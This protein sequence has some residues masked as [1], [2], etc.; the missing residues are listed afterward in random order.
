MVATASSIYA[1]IG[2][3]YVTGTALNAPYGT[4]L[5]VT[6]QAFFEATL[7]VGFI[8]CGF[9]GEKG[10][11][12]S[13]PRKFF[14][15]KDMSGSLIDS[16]Q[17][18]FSGVIK[19]TFLELN[20]ETLGNLHGD[21]N[22]ASTAATAGTGGRIAFPITGAP[23]D[24]SSWVFR[25]KAGKK[26]VGVVVPRA[27]VTTQSDLTFSA[28]GTASVDVEISTIPTY[29]GVLLANVSCYVITDDG[30][31]TVSTV[32]TIASVTPTG[33]GATML[34]TIIGTRFTGTVATTGV[35]FGATNATT[36]VVIS[37]SMI[38]AELPAGSAG[39]ANVTVTNAAGVST[40]FSYTRVV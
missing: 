7:N 5:P 18:G 35:K 36:W 3:D 38:V 24:P 20:A 26:R 27:R 1:G 2:P 39:A 23:L 11:V 10:V 33:Q 9:I 34:V 21:A 28:A 32:P 4:P 30:V 25:M 40:A 14:D 13:T 12:V 19:T 15:V 29:D 16:I 37:D 22:V 6:T 31:W 8:D 17:N